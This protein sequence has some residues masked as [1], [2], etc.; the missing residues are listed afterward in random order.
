MSAG[1]SMKVVCNPANS[2][3]SRT[4]AITG[5]AQGDDGTDSDSSALTASMS[6][7]AL[8]IAYMLI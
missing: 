6:F 8:I 2:V 3:T 4:G 5:G 7:V 1:V